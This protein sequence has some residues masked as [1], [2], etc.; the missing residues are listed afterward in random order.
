MRRRK[1]ETWVEFHDRLSAEA[2]DARE[3]GLAQRAAE[4]E[5][6]AGSVARRHPEVKSTPR[7]RSVGPGTYPWSQCITDN[8]GRYGPEGAKEV[9][10]RIRADSRA[11]HPD[12]WKAR[13][14]KPRSV[15]VSNPPDD[16]GK[17]FVGIG[18]DAGPNSKPVRDYVVIVDRYGAIIEIAEIR[19]PDQLKLVAEV[20]EDV[21]LIG[22][23]C[24]LRSDLRRLKR[25]RRFDMTHFGGKQ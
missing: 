7:A 19:T 25:S 11:R 21:P 1:S 2:K 12:Y 4:L 23:F 5:R 17:P 20:Y 8:E 24:V 9:C 10:G 22:P 18:L 15:A 6:R 3:A 13:G 14:Q 16:A